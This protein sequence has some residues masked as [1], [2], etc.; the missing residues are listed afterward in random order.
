T[1]SNDGRA[2]RRGG[3]WIGTMGKN[4]ELSAGTI[5]RYF[6]GELRVLYETISTPNAMCF[7][8]DGSTAY[9]ADSKTRHIMRQPLDAD[10]WPDGERQPF[11]QLDRG[12]AVPDGAVVDSEGHLWCALYRG[13]V[14]IRISPAGE[15][16][17]EVSLPATQLTCPAFGGPDL[18]TVFVT[19]ARQGLDEAAL[20]ERPLAGAVFA[21]E[22][23]TPGLP[24]QVVEL[25]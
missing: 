12:N 23:E 8:P 10:G 19:S 2:D 14:V 5:Y 16:V 21:F 9:V 3:F 11:F 13:S 6:R 22:I 4:G 17:Q 20:A 25:G 24:D 15:I 7:S 1:R 18:K